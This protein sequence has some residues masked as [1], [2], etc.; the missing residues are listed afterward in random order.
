MATELT[1]RRTDL[2]SNSRLSSLV[3]RD[4]GNKLK[5]GLS[6]QSV[7]TNKGHYIEL[8]ERKWGER[9]P[10]ILKQHRLDLEFA[11]QSLEMCEAV[12]GVVKPSTPCK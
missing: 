4:E 5:G 9:G 8:C 11:A 10:V 6:V 7:L 2:K 1:S 12:I 3:C